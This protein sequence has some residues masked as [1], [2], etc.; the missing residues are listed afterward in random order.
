MAERGF[1]EADVYLAMS[2]G[3]KIHAR[4]TLYYFLGKRDLSTFGNLAERLE[5]L[6]VVFN[7]TGDTVLTVYRNRKWTKK[8]RHKKWKRRGTEKFAVKMMSL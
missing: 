1:S 8:I 2:V 4:E 7:K 3:Q 6:T 5:G